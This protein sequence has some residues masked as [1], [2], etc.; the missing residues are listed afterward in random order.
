[1][2]TSK[3]LGALC[4]GAVLLSAGCTS[5]TQT[6]GHSSSGELVSTA[7]FVPLPVLDQKAGQSVAVTF[8]FD[9]DTLDGEAM[10]ILDAQAAWMIDRPELHFSVV[11]HA[12]RV[13]DQSYNFDLGLRRANRVV[14][15]L[16]AA[17]VERGRLDA[18]VSQGEDQPV[19]ST[20]G[21]ERLNRRVVIQVAGI[22]PVAAV[23]SETPWWRHTPRPHLANHEDGPNNSSFSRAG[24][25]TVTSDSSAR[26]LGSSNAPAS[27]VGEGIEIASSSRSGLGGSGGPAESAEGE[28]SSVAGTSG[29]SSS[30]ASET[31]SS[32]TSSPTGADGGSSAEGT[33]SV[34][35][36]SSPSAENKSGS[37][38]SG[39]D[40][41]SKGTGGNASKTNPSNDRVDAGGGN[42]PE[43]GGDPGASEGR[44][45]GGDD[46]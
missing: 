24:S 32:K 26:P 38:N 41:G 45:Q 34:Q 36:E 1:M 31:P 10:S 6:F 27:G 17:G 21:P 5:N 40:K 7:Q 15:Y 12:D 19:I 28:N 13:G 16:V 9:L 46:D 43:A 23:A 2:S 4:T 3:F 22:I 39:K 11:G 18:L 37:K 42:G 20:D 44:N 35:G 14:D 29:G 30:S 25:D 8:A 33:G